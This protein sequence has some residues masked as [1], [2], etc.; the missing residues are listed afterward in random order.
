[1]NVGGCVGLRSWFH[2]S[3]F[4]LVIWWWQW[5]WWHRFRI[6]ESAM[7]G[8]VGYQCRI[9]LKTADC[10][11]QGS[12]PSGLYISVDPYSD[13]YNVTLDKTL[14][15]TVYLRKVLSY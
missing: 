4:N 3:F 10:Y 5:W 13:V 6:A 1:M 15:P 14:F 8:D 11:H 7:S 9:R 12:S 2:L